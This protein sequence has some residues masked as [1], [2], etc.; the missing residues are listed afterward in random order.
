M[1]IICIVQQCRSCDFRPTYGQISDLQA[2]V[3]KGT[4]LLA[5]TATVTHCFR[6]EVMQSLE[7]ADC[8]FVSTSPDWP[9]IFYELHTCTDVETDMSDLLESLRQ[10]KIMASGVQC[11][12]WLICAFSLWVDEGLYYPLGSAKISDNRLFGMYHS[13][14][15]QH[16]KEVILSSLN[17]SAGVVRVLFATIALGMGVNLQEVNTIIRYG[18]PENIEDYFQENGKVEDLVN[19]LNQWFNGSH[20]IAHSRKRRQHDTTK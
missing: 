18:A 14:T 7:M 13:N 3:P 20:L 19:L 1:W 6:Q 15:P 11:V 8:V 5:C 2:L 17:K 9:N 10:L 12:C 4:P 16:N